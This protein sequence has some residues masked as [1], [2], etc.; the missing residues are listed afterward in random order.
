MQA[1]EQAATV[2]SV[3]VDPQ[4]TT[5][6]AKQTCTDVCN[7]FLEKHKYLNIFSQGDH[8]DSASFNKINTPKAL[9]LIGVDRAI[10]TRRD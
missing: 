3:Q 5:L 10:R 4:M 7:E 2:E 8:A 6:L 9:D 1:V